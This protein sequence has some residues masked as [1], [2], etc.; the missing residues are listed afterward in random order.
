MAVHFRHH[1]VE[2]DD[3]DQPALALEQFQTAAAIVGE[4][5]DMTEPLDHVRQQA[6]LDRIV[7]DDENL[8]CHEGLLLS[9]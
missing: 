9:A 5:G 3:V 2:Q 8:G 6:A 4:M 1:Q 7:I